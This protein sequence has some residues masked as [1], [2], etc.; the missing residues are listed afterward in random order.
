MYGWFQSQVTCFC[1]D[2][3]EWKNT[4]HLTI[5]APSKEIMLLHQ[6]LPNT[7]WESKENHIFSGECLQWGHESVSLPHEPQLPSQAAPIVKELK[8][9]RLGQWN[10]FAP[11]TCCLAVRMGF[12]LH[13]VLCYGGFRA[14]AGQP[15]FTWATFIYRHLQCT[16]FCAEY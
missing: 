12:S 10:D 6:I 7:S 2:F 1:R 16:Q 9:M 11:R 14:E 13:G 5:A 8:L 3:P 4:I 15:G